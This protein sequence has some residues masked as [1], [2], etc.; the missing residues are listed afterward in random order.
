MKQIIRTKHTLVLA[1]I[2]IIL[3]IGLCEQ[4]KAQPFR[5]GPILPDDIQ[6]SEAES[7]SYKAAGVI[8]CVLVSSAHAAEIGKEYMSEYKSIQQ[9]VADRTFP[10][11]FQAWSPADNL[12]GEDRLT[13]V[14]R[15]DLAF[16][17]LGSFRL[18]WK[19]GHWG[20]GTELAPES[21]EAGRAVR[22][23]LMEKNP[24]LILIAE[25]N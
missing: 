14:A 24:N 2:G 20:L 12:P 11:V 17:G 13:T 3:F 15:H 18:K 5:M 9:R 21:I 23:T 19:S 10:S 6:L 8:A 16:L 7:A 4:A 25:I 22:K 1:L